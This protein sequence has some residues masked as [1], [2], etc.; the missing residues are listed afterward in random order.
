MTMSI[1][2]AEDEVMRRREALRRSLTAMRERVSAPQLI[3]DALR[4]LDPQLSLL[5]HLKERVQHNRILSLAIL[6]GAGWLVGVPSGRSG[7]ARQA[8]Q[9]R[10][11]RPSRENTKEKSNVSRQYHRNE[12]PEP[13]AGDSEKGGAEAFL[14]ARRRRQANA[15]VGVAPLHVR[16]D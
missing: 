13:A 9:A 5:G 8:R 7:T 15:R 4:F 3:E 6:A 2:E 12:Q 16:R 11:T 10:A 14:E 1:E